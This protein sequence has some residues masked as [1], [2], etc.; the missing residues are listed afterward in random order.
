[1]EL[2]FAEDFSTNVILDTEL[3]TVP[4][5]GLYLN[6]GVHPSVTLGNIL[7][8]LPKL[9][10]NIDAWDDS[11]NYEVYSTTRDRKDLVSHNSKVYQC[12]VANINVEPTDANSSTWLETNIESLRLKSFVDKVKDKVF[13]DLNLTRR[14]I[15]NQYMRMEKTK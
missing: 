14:L 5:S 7:A 9:S 4:S 2:G 6:S 1:M 12:L 8:F 13:S 15:E 11:V 10:F 3:K